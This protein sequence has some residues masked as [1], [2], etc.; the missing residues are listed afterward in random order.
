M[1]PMLRLSIPALV[2]L[3]LPASAAPDD[4]EGPDLPEPTDPGD[5]AD[6]YWRHLPNPLENLY[7]TGFGYHGLERGFRLHYG[8]YAEA[9]NRID[10]RIELLSSPTDCAGTI[11]TIRFP[12]HGI[13]DHIEIEVLDE[14]GALLGGIEA[15]PG[16]LP[17]LFNGARLEVPTHKLGPFVITNGMLGSG[18]RIMEVATFTLLDADM[19][20]RLPV[21]TR[22]NGAPASAGQLLFATLAYGVTIDQYS[23]LFSYFKF[24]RQL[25]GLNATERQRAADA[26]AQHLYEP[27]PL[28]GGAFYSEHH[29]VDHGQAVG[30]LTAPH[31]YGGF[32][33][34]HRNF[35]ADLEADIRA[36]PDS[37]RTPFRRIPAWDPATTIPAEFDAGVDDPDGGADLETAFRAENI[38]DDYDTRHSPEHF[39]TDELIDMEEELWSDVNA[40]HN[41]VHVGVGGDFVD[42][43]ITASTV[44]FHPWHTTVDTI[45]RNWQL[46]KAAWYPDNYSWDE[47]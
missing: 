31:G 2:A 11:Y 44:I 27:G 13:D 16:A 4:P 25:G 28:H 40:W 17:V 41:S 29:H 15:S 21:P 3:A 47:L 32:F 42:F 12:I 6:C 39:L 33:N 14:S 43:N 8:D 34:G 18:N 38:C 45:W 7:F 10:Y 22:Y 19:L 20:A 24:R 30:P 9:N 5:I 36:E 26:I 37:N 23:N 1:K 46:C 35:L